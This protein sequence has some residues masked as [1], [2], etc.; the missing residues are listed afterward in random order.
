M[1]P[2]RS[3]CGFGVCWRRCWHLCG[4]QQ[5]QRVL[6][7]CCRHFEHWLRWLATLSIAQRWPTSG[8]QELPSPRSGGMRRAQSC[9]LP[10]AI[11]SASLLCQ[12]AGVY[13]I[14]CGSAPTVTE[15]NPHGVRDA[16]HAMHAAGVSIAELQGLCDEIDV[17][18]DTL[19]RRDTPG[20]SVLLWGHSVDA[21][22]AP[23]T[24]ALMGSVDG[25]HLALQRAGCDAAAAIVPLARAAACGGQIDVL[26]ELLTWVSSPSSLCHSAAAARDQLLT[27]VMHACCEASVRD[28]GGECWRR[29]L[30]WAFHHYTHDESAGEHGASLPLT[31][32]AA[33][34]DGARS[35]AA[36]AHTRESGSLVAVAHAAMRSGAVGALRWM[37]ATAERVAAFGAAGVPSAVWDALVT[38][39]KCVWAPALAVCAAETHDLAALRWAHGRGLPMDV[40]AC[41]ATALACAPLPTF[42]AFFVP[43]S[44]HASTTTS[45]AGTS[46]NNDCKQTAAAAW[47]HACA[48][49]GH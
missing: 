26:D 6:I 36:T 40:S 42:A 15:V 32:S 5:L 11:C 1:E 48:H 24:A 33:G 20:R 34:G 49:A 31:P 22:L 47:L 25:M 4:C 9:A 13:E 19:C 37:C 28:E 44:E 17:A 10:S 16:L 12:A 7:L 35:V 8:Q 29:G 27:L 43:R 21:V 18:M 38:D 30:R 41:H 23:A 14:K 39:C 2:A 45:A 46:A 3:T